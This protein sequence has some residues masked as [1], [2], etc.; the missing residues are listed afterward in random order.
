M[1]QKIY[2]NLK[3]EKQDLNGTSQDESVILYNQGKPADYFMLIL[4]GRVQTII[5]KENLIFESGPFSYFGI[6]ALKLPK[7]ETLTKAPS[8][9]S[10]TSQLEIFQEEKKQV[11]PS[12]PFSIASMRKSPSG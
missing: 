11:P 7:D 3:I 6:E 1:G 8:R 5:G 9:H 12:P 10:V 2:F 4:E